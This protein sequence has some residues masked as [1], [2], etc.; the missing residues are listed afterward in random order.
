MRRN[1][2]STITGYETIKCFYKTTNVIE[3]RATINV[4]SD[5]TSP[6][7]DYETG[8]HSQSTFNGTNVLV[9]KIETFDGQKIP[10]SFFKEFQCV[11][12]GF[13]EVNPGSKIEHTHKFYYDKNDLDMDKKTVQ[14]ST[15]NT[16]IIIL[17]SDNLDT[18]KEKYNQLADK[19]DSENFSYILYQHRLEDFNKCYRDMDSI[20]AKNSDKDKWIFQR[21]KENCR[22]KYYQEL[23]KLSEK[24]RKF[25][26]LLNNKSQLGNFILGCENSTN[27]IN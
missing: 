14:K 26:N 22:D 17:S 19:Y 9:T 2:G 10:T 1:T 24:E 21:V 27:T 4:D 15:L 25:I 8:K 16:D 11:T 13:D 20:S 5:D 7:F 6:I 18:I 23:D 3:L 12:Y